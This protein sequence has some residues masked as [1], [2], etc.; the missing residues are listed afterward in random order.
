MKDRRRFGGPPNPYTRPEI[1]DGKVNVTDPDSK[2]IK[3]NDT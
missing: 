3:A 1:P 2:R